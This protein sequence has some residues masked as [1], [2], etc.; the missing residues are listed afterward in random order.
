MKKTKRFSTSSV[1]A[2]LALL[3]CACTAHED[4][5]RVGAVDHEGLE[6]AKAPPRGKG[7]RPEFG[8]Q[9]MSGRF[10]QSSL[11]V[12][13]TTTELHGPRIRPSLLSTLLCSVPI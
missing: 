2:A 12:F 1:I 5:L 9:K 6:R 7:T 3:A 13:N 8:S 10:F 4:R 11:M